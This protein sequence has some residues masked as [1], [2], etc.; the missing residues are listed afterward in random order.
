MSRQRLKKRA[1]GG[2]PSGHA[3]RRW[4]RERLHGYEETTEDVRNENRHIPK[5]RGNLLCFVCFSYGLPVAFSN[6]NLDCC[7]NFLNVG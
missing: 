3:N 5:T 2:R 7:V 1:G 6:E 4:P